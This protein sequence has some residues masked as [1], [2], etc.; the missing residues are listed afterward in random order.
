MIGPSKACGKR[1][2]VEGRAA[3]RFRSTELMLAHPVLAP[4]YN[5]EHGRHEASRWKPRHSG[6]GRD[7]KGRIAWP[8]G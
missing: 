7:V 5:S 6:L 8:R 3:Y 1:R 2:D 4:A